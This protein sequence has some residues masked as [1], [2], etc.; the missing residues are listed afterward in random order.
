M[1]ALAAEIIEQPAVDRFDFADLA[2]HGKWLIPRLVQA[3]DLPEQRLGGWI[4]SLIDNREFLFLSQEH[5]CALAELQLVNG[6]ADRP[7]VRGRFVLAE[8]IDVPEY[9]QEAA[10]FYDKIHRWAKDVGADTVLLPDLND[11]PEDTIRDK[12][13]RVF[14]SEQRFVRV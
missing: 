7:V 12:F 13:G 6:L 1:M 14:R 5:S 8:N 11:V 9:V 3:L 4:R 10:A 2:R